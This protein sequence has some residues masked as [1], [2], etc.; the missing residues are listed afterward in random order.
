[1]AFVGLGWHFF[2]F[3]RGYHVLQTQKETRLGDDLILLAVQQLMYMN[4]DSASHDGN[5]RGSCGSSSTES[6]LTAAVLL[7]T[8]IHHSPHNSYL[9]FEAIRVYHELD[10]TGRSWEFFQAVGLKHIQLDSCTFTI[11]PFLL[12]GG[13]YN[14]TIEICNAM[15]RF[16]A[17]TARDCGEYAGR[18]M[19]A[20]TLS[21]A[22]E[23]LVFQ[24]HK[25]NKS[26]AILQ[27]KGLILDSAALLANVVPRKKHDEDPIFEG[28]LGI[29]QGIVGGDADMVRATQMVVE[30]HNPYAALS[31][32]SWA[33][34]GGSVEDCKEMADNR[35]L[36][37]LSY[38]I[39]LPSKIESKEDM[40]QDA[41]RRGHIHGLLIRST[42]C[43]EAVKVPKKGKIVKA[44]DE[45]EKRT[46][47]LL[48]CVKSTSA[49]V[50]NHSLSKGEIGSCCKALTETILDLCRVI[51][52]VSAGLPTMEA[53]K[54]DTLEERERQGADGLEGH[55]LKH[56]KEAKESLIRHSTTVKD[57]CSLLPNYVVPLFAIF[58][59]CSNLLASYGWGKRKRKTKLCANAMAHVALEFREII[60]IFCTTVDRHLPALESSN[61]GSTTTSFSPLLSSSSSS[62]S[63]DETSKMAAMTT[64]STIATAML[65]IPDEYHLLLDENMIRE[66]TDVVYQSRFRTRIR[67][68]PVL[69]EL[70]IELDSFEELEG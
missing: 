45:L 41:L 2:P 3:H 27:A 69:K 67:V 4:R 21:K 62:S 26:I 8:A 15:L 40:V 43:M 19:E 23:F 53:P 11:L 28:G 66:T 30:A 58:R 57:V 5:T 55:A 36:S 24:R 6:L 50:N 64:S 9:K 32:V 34:G 51:A 13:L 61:V 68:E 20:G 29:H 14:E 37:V 33:D 35:D 18:A 25:M 65:S 59:M 46:S 47:S 52:M 38:Q 63:V 49:F 10:A 7:E 12:A 54:T 16:Q 22:N 48:Q 60:Q 44:S 56:L 31:L 1:M 42:L 39:L 70:R 17:G